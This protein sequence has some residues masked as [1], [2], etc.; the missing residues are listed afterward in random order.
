MGI[1]VA[2]GGGEM[3]LKETFAIDQQIVALTGKKNPQALFIPTASGEPKGYVE[4]FKYIYGDSLRCL[5]DT[6]YLLNNELSEDEI[7]EK[8]LTS[9]LIYVGGGD[10]DRMLETWKARNVGT[11]LKEAYERG[12]VLA[13]LSA[14][15]ICWFE[16]GFSDS[17]TYR[18]GQKCDYIKLPALGFLKGIHC[19]H[20]NEDDREEKFTE[21]MAGWDETGIALDNCCALEVNGDRFR[22]LRSEENARVMKMKRQDGSVRKEMIPDTGEYHPLSGLY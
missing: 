10:T 15:S 18:A 1:I 5:P 13:G 8:I 3:H 2:I 16:Y 7:K 9:D 20:F 21:M 11:Y 4:C 22:I 6:L 12:I 19:P 14:G 17:L